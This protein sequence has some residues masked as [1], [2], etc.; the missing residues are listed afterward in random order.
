MEGNGNGEASVREKALRADEEVLGPLARSLLSSYLL[1]GREPNP[2]DE[3]RSKV[4]EH[5][6]QTGERS[7]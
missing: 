3:R 4:R 1:Q 5:T 2:E 6:A 7:G